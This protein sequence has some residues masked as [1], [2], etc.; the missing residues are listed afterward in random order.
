MTVLSIIKDLLAKGFTVD[1]AVDLSF[2]N[3]TVARCK[4]SHLIDG[5]VKYDKMYGELTTYYSI[6]EMLSMNLI[7]INNVRSDNTLYRIRVM[8]GSNYKMATVLYEDEATA[9]RC[10]AEIDALDEAWVIGDIEEVPEPKFPVN[11]DTWFGLNGEAFQ[12]R[13]I[14][15]VI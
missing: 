4:A 15:K 13:L 5:S 3:G 1:T 8:Y 11:Y 7:A 9:E 14:W 6:D 2:A 12:R 10:A